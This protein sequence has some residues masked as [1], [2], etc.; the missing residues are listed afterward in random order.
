MSDNTNISFEGNDIEPNNGNITNNDTTNNN[1]PL[2]DDDVVDIDTGATSDIDDPNNDNNVKSSDDKNDENLHD[3]EVGYIIEVDGVEYTINENKDL[4]DKDGNVFK[5]AKDIKSWLSENEVNDDEI[6]IENIQKY[7]NLEITDEQGKP[8]EFANT[9]EGVKS[10]IDSVINL[11]TNTIAEAT[12]NKFYSDNPLVKQFVDYVELTGTPKGFGE[13]PD[14]TGIVVNKDS[15]E[16]QVA[17]IKMAASEFG[18]K[19]LN[20][21]YIKYLEST[22]MLYE[23]AKTQL[24]AL[25]A[26]DKQTRKDI[27]LR[28]EQARE[29]ERQ[30]IENYFKKVNEVIT[31]RKLGNYTL[32]ETIIQERNG[33]KVTLTLNDFYDYVAKS[34]KDNEGNIMTGYQRDLNKQ[35]DDDLLSKELI[36]AWL[37]F[38]GGSYKDLVNM[39]VKEEQAKKLIIKSKENKTKHNIT[40]KKTTKSKPNINDV[41]FY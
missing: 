30:S 38:T 15:K 31:S 40:V 28:A 37:M 26:K 16:Q 20:D 35:S 4:V 10:Y 12:I 32:P 23:E 6:N 17:I 5:E 18:N 8:V 24:E 7:F 22:G 19:T 34:T 11:Q 33:K 39:I 36:D 13:I 29:E 14:R 1:N 2:N 25:Q 41:V 21:N 9:A 27:E 3:L